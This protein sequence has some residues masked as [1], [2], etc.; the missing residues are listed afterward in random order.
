MPMHP[1]EK[2]VKM[3]AVERKVHL[4]LRNF[5]EVFSHL[6]SFFV[7]WKINTQHSIDIKLEKRK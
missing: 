2:L 7:K 3:D 5:E 4:L 1:R 6:C